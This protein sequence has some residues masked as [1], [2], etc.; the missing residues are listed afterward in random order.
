[1][2]NGNL[3]VKSFLDTKDSTLNLHYDCTSD[4]SILLWAGDFN[5]SAIINRNDIS[6]KY[7]ESPIVNEFYLIHK[8]LKT[9]KMSEAYFLREDSSELNLYNY[10]RLDK[11]QTL[12]IKIILNNDSLFRMIKNGEIAVKGAVTFIRNPI[13]LYDADSFLISKNDTSIKKWIEMVNNY[14]ELI[15]EYSHY[16]DPLILKDIQWNFNRPTK[17]ELI[18][19]KT[20]GM[21]Y[22]DL[23]KHK[24]IEANNKVDGQASF[25]SYERLYRFANKH[26][27]ISEIEVK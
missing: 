16:L 27:F 12:K 20:W 3:E 1:M 25:L 8:K 9:F 18:N 4:F 5:I 19:G 13:N 15:P 2:L 6:S 17:K 11:G 21:H 22:A 10:R 26:Y 7:L 23:S 24:L 14:T